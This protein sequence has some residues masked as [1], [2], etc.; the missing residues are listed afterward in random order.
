MDLRQS[1]INVQEY[2]THT[3]IQVSANEKIE[4]ALTFS[5]KKFPD[6]EVADLRRVVEN[7]RVEITKTLEDTVTL[8]SAN[9]ALAAELAQ[10]KKELR[11]AKRAP[12]RTRPRRR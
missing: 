3:V 4:F 1:T 11:N 6:A 9:D 5:P 7:Q 12:K 8:S 10:A 2:G